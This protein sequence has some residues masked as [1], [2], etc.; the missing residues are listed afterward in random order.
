MVRRN[1]ASPEISSEFRHELPPNQ[2]IALDAILSGD[3]F[4]DAALKAGVDERTIRRWRQ[5]D[6]KFEASLR[7][8]VNERREEVCTRATIAA[9]KALETVVSIASDPTDSRSLRAA[10][11]LLQLSRIEAFRNPRVTIDDVKYDQFAA[12]I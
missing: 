11:L 8:S 9:A 2:V 10:M 6:H 3:S 5:R 7:R 4:R 1:E 12:N